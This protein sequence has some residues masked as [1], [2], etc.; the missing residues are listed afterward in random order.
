MCAQG[1]GT[2][3]VSITKQVIYQ[4]LSV[5]VSRHLPVCQDMENTCSLKRTKAIPTGIV[6][7]GN[8]RQRTVNNCT[9]LICQG[10][11]GAEN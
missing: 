7:G 8:E 9:T 2:P 3:L 11:W 5:K 1:D 4:P 6:I 10:F